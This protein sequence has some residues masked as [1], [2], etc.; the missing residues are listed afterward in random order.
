M[1]GFLMDDYLFGMDSGNIDAGKMT[2]DKINPRGQFP[3]AYT[4]RHAVD[5]INQSYPAP[6]YIQDID[7]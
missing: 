6:I 7:P 2:A 1:A 3:Q 5:I 4:D